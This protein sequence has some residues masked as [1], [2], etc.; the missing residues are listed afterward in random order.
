MTEA[1]FV[2]NKK[3]V[4][5]LILTEGDSASCLFKSIQRTQPKFFDN[6]GLLPLKGK[7][8]GVEKMGDDITDIENKEI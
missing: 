7:I 3:S 1:N 2:K 5:T 6:Y 4:C 8:L